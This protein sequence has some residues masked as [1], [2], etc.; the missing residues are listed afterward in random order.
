LIF[1]ISVVQRKESVASESEECLDSSVED[2][3]M[4]ERPPSSG[5]LKSLVERHEQTTTSEFNTAKIVFSF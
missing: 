1:S 3:T 4:P 5:Q 2:S